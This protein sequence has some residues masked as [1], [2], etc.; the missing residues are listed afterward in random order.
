MSD[1]VSI[2]GRHDRADSQANSAPRT[3]NLEV[4]LTITANLRWSHAAQWQP[5]QG[6]VV[7]LLD[8]A[9]LEAILG[10]RIENAEV[11]IDPGQRCLTLTLGRYGQVEIPRHATAITSTAVSPVPPS[12]WR[13]TEHE[14]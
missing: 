5:D 13:P 7:R 3:V 12:M 2:V 6:C 14:G 9:I 11:A 4:E 8:P 1:D 10:Y